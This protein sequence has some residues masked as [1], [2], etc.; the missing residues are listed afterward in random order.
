MI[1]KVEIRKILQG[2]VEG[3]VEVKGVKVEK[4]V[5]LIMME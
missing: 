1:L 3:I 2:R 5:I 4:I